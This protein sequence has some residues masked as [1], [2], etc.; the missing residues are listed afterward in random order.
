MRGTKESALTCQTRG[1]FLKFT[2]MRTMQRSFQTE[3]ETKVSERTS[4]PGRVSSE[5]GIA[6]CWDVQLQRNTCL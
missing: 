5:S 1:K 6:V 3:E 2:R 4:F